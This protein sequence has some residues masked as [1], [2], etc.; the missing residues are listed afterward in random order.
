LIARQ[1]GIK[2]VL[3]FA[4][5]CHSGPQ[6]VQGQY[7]FGHEVNTVCTGNLEKYY[8]L[9]NTEPEIRQELKQQVADQPAYSP[10]CLNL[11][12]ELSDEKTDGFGQDYDG[13]IR[14]QQVV[15]RC[16]SESAS[17]YTTHE[18]LHQLRWILTRING[19][20][21]SVYAAQLGFTLESPLRQIPDLVFGEQDILSGNTGCNHYNTRVTV[22]KEHAD[23]G[24]NRQYL[25]G[26]P[27]L[28]W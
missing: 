27:R 23:Y 14:V 19:F 5:A 4:G 12:A 15:G 26:L 13:S 11:M 16:D 8:W 6:Q 22:K 25:H 21:L 17:A 7:Q 18:D 28:C 1:I 10:V 3:F 20:D 9:V 24:A 2:G